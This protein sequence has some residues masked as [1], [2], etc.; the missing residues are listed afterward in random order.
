M[1]REISVPDRD[2]IADEAVPINKPLHEDQISDQQIHR[3]ASC[4]IIFTCTP[5][6]ADSE[7]PGNIQ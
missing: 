1:K 5:D 4:T 2:N 6:S 3:A 7:L